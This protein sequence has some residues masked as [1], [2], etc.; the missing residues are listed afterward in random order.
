MVGN[1]HLSLA[2]DVTD[3][4]FDVFHCPC[5]LLSDLGWLVYITFFRLS[6]LSGPSGSLA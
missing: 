4:L 3:G 2:T 6:L 1:C 5:S